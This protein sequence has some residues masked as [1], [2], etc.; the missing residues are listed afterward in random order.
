MRSKYNKWNTLH[1]LREFGSKL[2][3]IAAPLCEVSWLRS[4]VS[5]SGIAG[6]HVA[7]TLRF[8]R[9]IALPPARSHLK[10][11]SLKIVLSF[12]CGAQVLSKPRFFSSGLDLGR[13]E[14]KSLQFYN[15]FCVHLSKTTVN[16]D[17]KS[18]LCA[19]K[20]TF[21]LLAAVL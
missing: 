11:F 21:E 10:P 4:A 8:S 3:V 19:R 14:F 1:N 17:S 15:T 7:Q 20:C 6:T 9:F 13:L 12:G 16:I 5:P 18:K 2:S